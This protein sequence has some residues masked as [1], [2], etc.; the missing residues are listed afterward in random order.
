MTSVPLKLAPLA[1]AR[2]YDKVMFGIIII[3]WQR[4]TALA[5]LGR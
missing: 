1:V 5:L 2:G 4:R 3:V